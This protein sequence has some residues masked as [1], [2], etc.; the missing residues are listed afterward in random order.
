MTVKSLHKVQYT[1]VA[2]KPKYAFGG[3][4]ACTQHKLQKGQEHI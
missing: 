4:N 2:V 1:T 3:E